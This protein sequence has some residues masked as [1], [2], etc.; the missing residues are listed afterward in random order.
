M[1]RRKNPKKKSCDF[2]GRRTRFKHNRDNV[3]EMQTQIPAAIQADRQ[4]L[5]MQ[6]ASDA[7]S[8]DTV[9]ALLPA[10]GLQSFSTA[11]AIAF[12]GLQDQGAGVYRHREFN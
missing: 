3:H 10:G 12:C 4:T 7:R 2:F 8:I 11:G 9:F 1:V 5:S 6:Q